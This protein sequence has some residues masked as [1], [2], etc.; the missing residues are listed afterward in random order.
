MRIVLNTRS[1]TMGARVCIFDLQKRLRHVGIDA[2]L[3]DW[4]HYDRYDVVVFM[5]YDEDIAGAREQNPGI[6]IAVA[7][8]KQNRAEFRRAAREADFL[9]VSSVEQRDVFYR[10]N[11]SILVYCMFPVMER[12]EKEHSNHPPLVIGYHGNRTHLECMANG[13]QLALNELATRR[14]IEFWAMYNIRRLGKAHLGM[15]DD[16]LMRVRHI[17]WSEENYRAELGQVDIGIVPNEIPIRNRSRVLDVSAYPVP[18][19]GYVPYDYLTRYKASSN[20][21]RI[22]VF[23]QLGIPVVSDFYP[24]AAQLIVDGQSGFLASSPQGWYEALNRLAK[25]VD[26]RSRSAAHLRRICEEVADPINQTRRFL[27]YCQCDTPT[28]PISFSPFDIEG[29]VRRARIE[30]Y[31][32][33]LG[34]LWWRVP[35]LL[36]SLVFPRRSRRE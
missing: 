25:S 31:V 33:R 13:V 28:Q 1:N 18:E 24:S 12:V 27:R 10:Y 29:A 5:G 15:P 23:G 17:Q 14:E 32:S 8:P 21:G 36:E 34:R 30:G 9:M 35:R 16:S 6:R 3:N 20:P 2:Q 4:D 19:F 26:L 11:R 7:D 22:Y